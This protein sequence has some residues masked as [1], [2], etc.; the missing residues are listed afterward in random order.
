VSVDYARGGARCSLPPQVAAAIARLEA[1]SSPGGGGGG[2]G[3]GMAGCEGLLPAL[4]AMIASGD[5][6]A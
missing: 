1:A 6:E 5:L 3:D 4:E 2:G